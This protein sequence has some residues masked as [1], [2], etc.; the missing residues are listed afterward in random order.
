MVKNPLAIKETQVQP[1]GR[2]DPLEK[3][4]GTHSFLEDGM[5]RGACTPW[6]SKQPDTTGPLTF[7]HLPLCPFTPEQPV[8]IPEY[9]YLCASPI[10]LFCISFVLL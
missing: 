4:V 9:C 10:Y 8:F 2:D 3:R 6:D 5:N 7:I 1:L